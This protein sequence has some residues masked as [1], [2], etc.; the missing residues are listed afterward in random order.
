MD[1]QL[2]KQVLAGLCLTS[3][4]TSAALVTGCVK[5]TPSS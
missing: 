1:K 4:I 2:M 3:L 5:Q